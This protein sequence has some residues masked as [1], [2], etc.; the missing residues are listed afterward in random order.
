MS[1][2][3]RAWREDDDLRLLEVWPDAPSAPAQAFRARLGGHSSTG[4][5][6]T[7]VATDQEVP[8]AAGVVYDSPWHPQRLWAYVE[9][10]PD[11]QGEGI[12]STL[13]TKLREAAANSPTGVDAL[14]TRVSPESMGEAF[15]ESHGFHAVMRARV[16]RVEA[17]ALP[18][19]SLGQGEAGAPEQ[20]VEDLATGSVELT[21][22]VWEFYR[23][24]HE[25][26]PVGE[27]GIG[28]VNQQLL[29]DTSGAYGAV[30]L[31]GEATEGRAK[32]PIRAFAISYLPFD[33]QN[34]QQEPRAGEAT[35]V[36]LGYVPED[37]KSEDAAGAAVE[38]LLALLVNDYPVELEVDDS[39][40]PL[41]KVVDNLLDSGVASVV[42]ES[43][44]LSTA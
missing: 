29:S 10:A 36:L 20:T 38:T 11:R 32:G 26:D 42:T 19:P 33:P 31:R 43:I 1:V 28:A 24:V 44:T 14:R 17:G 12:G 5:S 41:V 7:V 13:L 8:V 15:A 4:F 3:Y 35:D 23:H 22:A 21:K 37:G 18:V 34:P 27:I 30:V 2:D 40:G 9:V 16:I 6:H 39:M 25:W